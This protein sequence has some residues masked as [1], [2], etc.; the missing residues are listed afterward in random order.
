MFKKAALGISSLAITAFVGLGMA[1][2]AAAGPATS[3][4]VVQ[5]EFELGGVETINQNS[6]STSRNHGGKYLYITTKEMGYG[7]NPF[8]K[9]NGSNVKSIGSTIIGGRPIVGWYY[10]WD[11]S[12]HQQGTFEYQK[13][14]INAPFNT[15]RTS[16]YIQ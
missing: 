14:S 1:T 7:Q 12:G 6:F 15:M 3:L 10:K 2:E 13:T 5:V 11:A 9:M 8:A 16:I 4:N